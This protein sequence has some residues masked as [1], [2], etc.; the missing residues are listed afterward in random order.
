MTTSILLACAIALAAA[1]GCAASAREIAIRAGLVSVDSAR[2]GFLAYDRAH[3]LSLTAHC[4]PATETREQCAAKVAASGAALAAYQ[5]K[6]AK[7]DPLFT[8]AYRFLAAAK[9]LDDDPS[10]AGMQAA[11]A[12]L[13][14]ALAPFLGGK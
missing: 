9:I 8:S 11:I 10:I 4:D 1:T 2:D 5:V 3:E 13:I 12:Q 6:R 14:S 7:I